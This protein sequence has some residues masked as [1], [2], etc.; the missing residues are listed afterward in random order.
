ML[1]C[2]VVGQHTIE[3]NVAN[4]A[5][6]RRETL[7]YSIERWLAALTYLEV[8]HVNK[9]NRLS[10]FHNGVHVLVVHNIVAKQVPCNPSL[11]VAICQR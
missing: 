7:R 6:V 9:E 11:I 1:H 4:D 5:E 10:S 8:S 3:V 2:R